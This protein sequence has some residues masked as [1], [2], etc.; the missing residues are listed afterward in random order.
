MDFYEAERRF[1]VLEDQR[2]RGALNEAQYRTDLQRLRVTDSL[3]RVWMLQERT[4][5][6]HVYQNGQWIAAQPPQRG[7]AASPPP[8]SMYQA[9]PSQPARQPAAP[10]PAQPQAEKGGGCGKVVLYLIGWTVLWTVIAVVV[11]LVWGE[12]EPLVLAGVAL[13][14]LIS[15]VLML[16]KLSSSWS[17]Q[18]VDIRVEKVSTTDE[19][20]YTQTEKVRY[21]YVRRDNGKT[22]K[23][24]ARRKW[25]VG[26][27]LEKRRGEGKIRH[28]PHV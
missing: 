19:D 27:R 25:Q 21:A 8:P 5:Q 1:R 7:P 11:F 2:A 10:V 23:L 13:A 14:A 12:E 24:Q 4:G 20:G 9:T 28:Y 26:D 16:I 6:W 18:I 22:K 17:G 15:L 3:R